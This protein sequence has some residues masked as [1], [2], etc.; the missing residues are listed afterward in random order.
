MSHPT[1]PY[2]PRIIPGVTQ[3]VTNEE[4]NKKYQEKTQSR[5][6]P[7]AN[8][9]MMC[10][11]LFGNPPDGYTKDYLHKKYKQLAVSLHPD[12]HGGDGAPFH[13]LTTCYNHLKAS[14]PTH[15]SDVPDK[16]KRYECVAVPPPDSL[17]DSKFDPQVFNSY[18]TKNAFKQESQG[19]GDWLKSHPNL[20]QPQRPSESNF[21]ARI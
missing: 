16:S 2:V 21:N 5:T 7:T 12:K 8:L 19:Y 11:Q 3:R 17:F 15:M 10:I 18:Y 9:D 14:L 1:V 4:M 20:E 6:N 13:M